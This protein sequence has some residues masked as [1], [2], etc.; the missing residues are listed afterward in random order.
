MRNRWL[1][2]IGATGL[3]LTAVLLMGGGS[4]V[5]ADWPQWRGPHR[6]GQA[7]E[8]FPSELPTAPTPLW[9]HS[10]RH[11]YASPV[12]VSNGVVVMDESDGEEIVQMLDT[13]TGA[14]RWVASIGPVF[15]D[16]FEPGPRCTPLVEGDRV[17]VQ[18]ALGEFRCLALADGS[19]RW[20]F[21][22]GDYGMRW[23]TDR[24]SNIGAASRRGNAGSAVIDGDRILV[25]VGST[26]AASIVAFDKRSG[27]E[28]WRSQNDLTCFTSPVIGK[29][30]GRLHFVTA[31]C[32]GL[33]AL[34]PADGT[35]LWRVPFKTGANRNVLTP[36][37]TEDTVYFASH[38]TGLRAT[39]IRATDKGVTA[40]EAWLN[41]DARINLSSPVVFGDHLYGL[42]ARK[43]FIC[44][45][46]TSGALAWSQPGFGEVASTLAS[47]DRLLILTDLGELCLL[48]ADP[49]KYRELGRFQACGKTFSHPAYA[50]GVLYVRDPRELKAYR[51][52]PSTR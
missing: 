1:R 16:E 18:S 33:L 43:D 46:R 3:V 8:P 29:L 14:T 5:A 4:L 42:G 9:K 40:D 41:R 50:D 36:V 32:E 24:A 52:A 25:Q 39:R 15:T 47:G 51:L 21:H 19:V 7:L 27:R 31:T 45:N 11:G 37:L 44:V 17:Y 22:F 38:T 6:D 23:V 34:D 48:A 35:L 13:G 49:A 28:L 30:A 20:R 2:K 12:V 26:N 10:L